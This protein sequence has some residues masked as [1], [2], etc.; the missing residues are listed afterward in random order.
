MPE[1]EKKRTEMLCNDGKKK[2]HKVFVHTWWV[3]QSLYYTVWK[4]S[5]Y[6]VFSG[7]Y[8]PVF[9]M[10]TEIYGV[11]FNWNSSWKSN[12]ECIKKLKKSQKK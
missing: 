1:A 5:K 9:G 11:S 6:G 4:V 12:T 3:S 2:L 8:F 10:N 7:P